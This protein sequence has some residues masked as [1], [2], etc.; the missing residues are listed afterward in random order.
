MKP[1]LTRSQ[2]ADD[3]ARANPHLPRGEIEKIIGAILE[4]MRAA[5]AAGRRIELRGFGVFAAKWRAEHKACNPRSGALVRVPGMWRPVFR[6][7]KRLRDHLNASSQ[8]TG[9]KPAL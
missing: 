7:G 4:E 2:L 3:L 5:L 1:V 8:K 6:A 9:R